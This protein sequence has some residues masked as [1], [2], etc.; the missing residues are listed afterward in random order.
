[1]GFNGLKDLVMGIGI[2]DSF[3]H[4][5]RENGLD[6]IKL[7]HHC[8]TTGVIARDIARCIEYDKPDSLFVTGV[9]HD[10]GTALFDEHFAK[11][12]EQVLK[13]ANDNELP[14]EKVETK[15]LGINHCDMAQVILKSWGFPENILQPIAFHHKEFS[16]L[17]GDR[18]KFKT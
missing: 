7:W 2:L 4:E 14:I 6:R 3:N 12:Y 17:K 9:L 1:M 13:M 11:E 5:S 16:Q 18:N 10:I 8:I 15:M